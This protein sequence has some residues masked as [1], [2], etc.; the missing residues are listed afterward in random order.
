MHLPVFKAADIGVI[1]DWHIDYC[2]RAEV[3]LWWGYVSSVE[4]VYGWC[5]PVVEL[6]CDFREASWNFEWEWRGR[7]FAFALEGIGS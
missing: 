7:K 1:N 2:K 4:R 5:K 3:R 6:G